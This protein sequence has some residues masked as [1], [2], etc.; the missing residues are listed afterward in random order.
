[1]S[2]VEMQNREP[3]RETHSELHVT[4]V[5]PDGADALY[6]KVSSRRTPLYILIGGASHYDEQLLSRIEQH[7]KHSTQLGLSMF[8]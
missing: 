7:A 6:S 3:A 2:T 4:N 5:V 8:T 1:M